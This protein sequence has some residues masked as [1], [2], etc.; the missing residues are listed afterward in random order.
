MV[1]KEG[2]PAAAIL[3]QLASHTAVMEGMMTQSVRDMEAIP[4]EQERIEAGKAVIRREDMVESVA[5]MLRNS[6]LADIPD[7]T[8]AV[9]AL[10]SISRVHAAPLCL[11]RRVPRRM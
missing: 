10:S 5:V 2:L 4:G 7:A 9:N 3:L 8:E 6:G 1:G 11:A